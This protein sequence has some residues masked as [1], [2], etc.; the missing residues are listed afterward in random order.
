MADLS[1][2]HYQNL[3]LVLSDGR[4][5]RTSIPAQINEGDAVRH[6][7]VTPPMPLPEGMEWSYSHE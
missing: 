6:V 7:E 3:T 5:I 1:K 2:S 4:Q